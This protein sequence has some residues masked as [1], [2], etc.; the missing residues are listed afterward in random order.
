VS[1]SILQAETAKTVENP[2]MVD[3][4][5]LNIVVA[6]DRNEAGKLLEDNKLK[7]R[8]LD[9]RN[10]YLLREGVIDKNAGAAK[11]LTEAD[12]EARHA[13]FAARKRLVDRN[14]DL[15]ISKTRL[16]IRNLP[17]HVMELELRKTC[18]SAV[19]QFKNQVKQGIRTHLTKEEQEQGWDKKAR[20]VQVKVEKSKD[21]MDAK[22]GKLRSKGYAFVEWSSHAHALAML[23]YM[24]GNVDVFKSGKSLIVEFSLENTKVIKRLEQR[25]L[26]PP[27][28]NGVVPGKFVNKPM[29]P[30]AKPV[31]RSFGRDKPIGAFSKTG[32]KRTFKSKRFSK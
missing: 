31:R 32:E 3:G 12:L 25:K 23:R 21:R 20:I 13:S 5:I 9:R 19:E 2:F 30:L 15:Y 1:K 16:S 6:V 8:H 10:L 27:K 24:N 14:P 26:P 18:V 22:T 7:K 29:K 28:T 4:R 17:L 11:H